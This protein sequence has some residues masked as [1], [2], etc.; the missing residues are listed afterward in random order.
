[1]KRLAFILFLII[2]AACSSDDDSGSTDEDNGGLT[3]S[4][5]TAK[6]NGNDFE[7]V[8]VDRGFR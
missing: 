1:M 4:F 5:I 8:S 3:D 2:L 6:I 7:A